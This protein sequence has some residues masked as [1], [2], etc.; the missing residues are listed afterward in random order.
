M[1]LIVHILAENIAVL[2]PYCAYKRDSGLPTLYILRVCSHH[3][4]HLISYTFAF[5]IWSDVDTMAVYPISFNQT[6]VG[7]Y[8]WAS[9]PVVL[10]RSGLLVDARHDTY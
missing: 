7:A 6:I 4:D 9:F 2:R 3:V 1:L 10:D 5:N 8:S